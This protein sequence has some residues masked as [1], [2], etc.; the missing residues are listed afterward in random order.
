MSS[1]RKILIID[2]S[3]IVLRVAGAALT[4][5]GYDVATLNMAIGSGAAI[6]RE[7]PDLVLLDLTMPAL[8]G[9]D[10][11]RHVRNHSSLKSTRIA[12][13]SDQPVNRIRE[14][15]TRSGADGWIVKTGDAARL[16]AEVERLL[17]SCA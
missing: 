16:V 5:A 12:L 15:A 4:E 14:I 1:R 8:S 13:F 17:S 3:E 2:D 6:L 9:E 7:R 11:V 10:V